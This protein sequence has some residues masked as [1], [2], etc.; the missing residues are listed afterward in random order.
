MDRAGAE[1]AVGRFRFNG[2]SLYLGMFG[3]PEARSN[4]VQIAVDL[5]ALVDLRHGR[6]SISG[7][8]SH[9]YINKSIEPTGSQPLRRV[10]IRMSA[11]AGSGGSCYS[12]GLKRRPE[13]RR[14]SNEDI[15][16]PVSAFWW[17]RV[18]AVVRPRVVLVPRA[19][20]L[21]SFAVPCRSRK[22]GTPFS[23]S[24]D[25][26]T[27]RTYGR[28]SMTSRLPGGAGRE[29]TRSLVPPSSRRRGRRVSTRQPCRKSCGLSALIHMA[30]SVLASADWGLHHEPSVV[31]PSGSWWWH[32]E[33]AGKRSDTGAS[34]LTLSRRA[35]RS[36]WG[37]EHAIRGQQAAWSGRGMAAPVCILAPLVPRHSG[38]SRACCHALPCRVHLSGP[39]A[40]ACLLPAWGR[41]GHG[42]GH[43]LRQQHHVTIHG[44]GGL[45]SL[46]SSSMA[47][48]S[49]SC[50]EFAMR[51]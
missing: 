12:V 29:S 49:L 23:S 16:H 22:R 42:G 47:C 17:L 35:V 18:C 26:L 30:A 44:S 51:A 46:S 3:L 11:A 21:T 25:R 10:A 13:Q 8:G 20:S 48:S 50:L 24:H 36:Y 5:I 33:V 1:C 38:R 34:M 28:N 27:S 40:S 19:S 6:S 43:S 37:S 32:G 7:F 14:V 2:D 41:T 15:E 31:S 39:I 9:E 45:R 4:R